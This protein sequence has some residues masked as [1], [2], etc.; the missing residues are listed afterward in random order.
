[1]FG[2]NVYRNGYQNFKVPGNQIYK[3]GNY[4]I[5]ADSSQAGYF[6]AAGA[7]GG[8]EITVEG[9][10]RDSKQGDLR[11]AQVL[12]MMGCRVSYRSNGISVQGGSLSAVE[13]DMED[14]P[15]MVPTLAVVAAFARGTTHI[16]NV[17][18][19]RIK[20]SDRLNAVTTELSKMGIETTCTDTGLIVKGGS[21]T[22][23][24]ID[25]YEDHRIAMSF[26]IAGLSV[27]GVFIKNE[28]CVEKSFPEFWETLKRL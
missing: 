8:A 1:M 28:R 22:G 7:I 10:T 6:W 3:R 25:T 11:F 12:E 27:P 15:D 16:N 23:A 9:I 24:V 13:V 17:A 26:A 19:L 2:V 20:E 5:E 18:H 4:R 21:P 14:M